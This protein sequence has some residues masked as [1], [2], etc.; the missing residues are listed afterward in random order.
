MLFKNTARAMSDARQYIKE[1]H[2]ANCYR[3]HPDYGER[4]ARALGLNVKQA[5]E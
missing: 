4:V 1:R 5:T 3:V 2:S